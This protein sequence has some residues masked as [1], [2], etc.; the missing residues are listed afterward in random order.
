MYSKTTP[1]RPL[2]EE[3]SPCR[4][5]L[6]RAILG[7]RSVPPALAASSRNSARFLPRFL[8]PGFVLGL[9][10]SLIFTTP[11]QSLGWRDN[12]LIAAYQ[13]APFFTIPLAGSVAAIQATTVKEIEVNSLNVAATLHG[14]GLG[15]RDRPAE[16]G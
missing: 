3:S 15:R 9:V 1:S 5:A 10:S 16:R 7:R 2:P 6:L 13:S 11:A 4:R 12:P 8:K 14:I